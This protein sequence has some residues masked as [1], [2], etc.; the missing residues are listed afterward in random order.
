M[1]EPD[2]TEFK[3]RVRSAV[4][5]RSGSQIVAQMVMWGATIIVVRLLDP[6]DY[7][8]FAMTQVILVL[9]NFLNGDSFSSSLIQAESVDKK[10]I[11]QVFGMLILSNGCLAI[12]QFMAAPLAAAYF[13]QPIITDMLRTQALLYMATPFISLPSALLA[14]G[15]DFRKQAAANMAAALAGAATAL[16][17]AELGFGVWTLVY[18]P[19]ALFGVRAIGLTYA[20]RLLVWPTFN[21]EGASHMFRFGGA[22]LICQMLW[23]IQ[24]QS[25]IFIAGRVF[26]PHHLGLYAEALFVTL[27]FTGKFIPPLNE[28]AFPA[29]AN[30]AK[31]GGHIGTAFITSARLTMFVALPLYLGLAI[32]AEPL[33]ATLFGEKWLEMAPLVSG[34]AL[35]MPCFA[36]QILCSPA[37][38]A[39]G[40]PRIYLR[41]S[42]SGAIIMPIAFSIGL[43]WGAQGLVHAWQVAAPLLLIVTLALTLPEIGADW[44]KLVAALVPSIIASG[45]MASMVYILSRYT[46]DLPAPTELAV[47]VAFGALCYLGLLWTFSRQTLEQIFDLV[48]RRKIAVV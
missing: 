24:S 31:E 9:F 41:S 47:L 2:E 26:D 40:K 37:T 38:N 16:T 27:I 42:I 29:Y 7:G 33:V 8:L 5:W 13:R 4:F 45:V 35:A 22:L 6:S 30:L 10:R 14:R 46:G 15:L 21:F 17:C 18:A 12:A 34:L 1:S 28:V 43:G 20:A 3:T 36:L 19:I 32:V 44:R 48:F 39:L 11:A 25:D 23:I